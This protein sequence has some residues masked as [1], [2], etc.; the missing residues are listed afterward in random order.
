MLPPRALIVAFFFCGSAA[1]AEHELGKLS[2]KYES[3]GR[4]PGTVSTG[5]GDPGGVSYGTYQLASK[6]GRADDFV[7]RHYPEEFKGLKAG[8]DEFTKRWKELAAKDPKGLH[9]NEHAYIKETH[10]DPQAR[11]LQKD[12][13]LDVTKRSAAFR[14]VVWSVAVQHGPNTALI[15]AALKPLAKGGK[16][17]GVS[18][19]AMVRAIYA[20]RGRMDKDGKLVHFRRVSDDWIPRLTRRFDGELKDALEML[21][22]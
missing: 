5:K 1:A 19:E 17:D 22:K 11:K 10:Y 21:K 6:V 7:K 13:G 15:V 18:D 14:D 2:E 12:L 4:G 3:G 8:A 9:A 16:L 20:E